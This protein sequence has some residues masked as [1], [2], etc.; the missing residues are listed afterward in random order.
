MVLNHLSTSEGDNTCTYT[1]KLCMFHVIM[2]Y[3]FYMMY[4][5][6]YNH[7]YAQRKCIRLHVHVCVLLSPFSFFPL[8][9]LLPPPLPG[10][11][12]FQL[13]RQQLES[14]SINPETGLH[15]PDVQEPPPLTPSAIAKAVRYQEEMIDNGVLGREGGRE[16]GRKEG[17]KRRREGGVGGKRRERGEEKRKERGRERGGKG[18][19][20]GERDERRENNA[21]LPLMVTDDFLEEEDD[22]KRY[23]DRLPSATLDEQIEYLEE[24][25]EIVQ[26]QYT[27]YTLKRKEKN[28]RQQL[29]AVRRQLRQQ[30]PR[31]SGWYGMYSTCI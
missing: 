23:R 18:G 20:K 31:N 27:G 6:M 28:L 12:I 14:A 29:Y 8:L 25:L 26:S 11:K 13:A 16:G 4:M 3:M 24:K 22:V 9:P 5:Y 17:R 7:V 10:E 30:R 1:C 15:D 2:V 21:L 19:K